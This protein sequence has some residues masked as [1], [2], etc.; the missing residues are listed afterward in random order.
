MNYLQ[1][2]KALAGR[3]A[4]LLM[5]G[6][7]AGCSGTPVKTE[8][9]TAPQRTVEKYAPADSAY[10]IDQSDPIEGFNRG[11]YH[12]NAWFDRTI[13]LPVVGAYDFIL[14]DP[15]KSGVHNFFQNVGDVENLVN[16]ILQLKPKASLV[17]AGRLVVNTTVGLLGIW[18]PATKMGLNRQKEDFGQTLGRYGVGNGAYLVLPILG[19]SNVRD[20]VGTGVDMYVKSEIDPLFFDHNSNTYEIAVRTTDALD[21]RD[22]IAFRYYE[23]GSPFEYELVRLMYLKMREAEI[24]R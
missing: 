6:I 8:G 16:S 4:A 14:P 7:L 11:V 15:V 22:N 13:F 21:Q 10:V 24:A 5:I 1:Q 2:K 18:D 20:T 19:P 3:L 17:T 9:E 12:F 23:T